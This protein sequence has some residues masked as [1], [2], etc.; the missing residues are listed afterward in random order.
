MYTACLIG[1]GYWG[2]KLARNFQNSQFF[3]IVSIADKKYKNLVSAKK[4]YPLANYFKDYKKYTPKM[5]IYYC[6][7]IDRG[8]TF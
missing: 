8:F 6:N 4:T 3:D 7:G 5:Y 1:Y 2:S